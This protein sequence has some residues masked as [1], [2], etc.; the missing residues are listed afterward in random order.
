M[1]TK[2]GASLAKPRKTSIVDRNCLRKRIDPIITGSA[3]AIDSPHA[4]R[5]ETR[6][7]S[8]QMIFAEHRAHY[9]SGRGS[10]S[11]PLDSQNDP[12]SRI[13]AGPGRLRRRS[14]AGWHA[15]PLANHRRCIHARAVGIEVGQSLKGDDVVRIL[16]RLKLDRYARYDFDYSRDSTKGRL[17]AASLRR[18]GLS[19]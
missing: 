16:N 5:L 4:V 9:P 11:P 15:L 6:V 13:I 19:R 1:Q 17:L 8:V 3:L 7:F 18:G 12:D 10:D 14:I 2:R